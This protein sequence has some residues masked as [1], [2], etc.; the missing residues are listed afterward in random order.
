MAIKIEHINVTLSNIDTA[1]NALQSIFN[2]RIR[3]EGDAL[4]NGRT[5]HIGGDDSYLALYTHQDSRDE[6]TSHKTIGHLNHIGIV[7]D[8]LDA[9]ESKVKQA[10]FDT[11]NHGDYEP[12]RRFYFDLEEHIEM[13]VVSY[14]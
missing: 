5:I 8:D 13:E 10:G 1:A 2:W 9:I 14:A 11:Y 4:D 6:K 3:W 12:G 7:V